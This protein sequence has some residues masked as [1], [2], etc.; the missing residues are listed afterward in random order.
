[1]DYSIEVTQTQ[2]RVLKFSSLQKISQKGKIKISPSRLSL[3]GSSRSSIAWYLGCISPSETKC[4]LSKKFQWNPTYGGNSVVCDENLG[5]HPRPAES[6]DQ[7]LGRGRALQ[8]SLVN[9]NPVVTFGLV[10][11]SWNSVITFN[12][13][14]WSQQ[15]TWMVRSPPHQTMK[16]TH[17][18]FCNCELQTKFQNLETEGILNTER[19]LC[20]RCIAF[21]KCTV[22]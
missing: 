13:D 11:Y 2:D 1:M 7:L 14:N 12:Q 15:L 8:T 9:Y 18:P 21:L 17:K 20:N 6:L 22:Y 4:R 3:I 10:W 16:P 5:D 19:L